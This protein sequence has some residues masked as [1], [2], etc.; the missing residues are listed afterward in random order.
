[1]QSCKPASMIT[2]N[3]HDEVRRMRKRDTVEQVEPRMLNQKQAET[4]TGMGRTAMTAWAERIG[5][6]R[7]FGRAV[8]YDRRV[9][10]AALDAMSSASDGTR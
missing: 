8:R 4:Y 1:M 5:A 6:K 9:I 3:E 7:H 2:V 10:D